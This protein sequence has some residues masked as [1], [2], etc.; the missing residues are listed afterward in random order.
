M[1]HYDTTTTILK[2]LLADRLG[3]TAIEYALIAGLVSIA[4][5]TAMSSMG[6]TIGNSFSNAAEIM[7]NS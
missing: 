6:N 3:A 5:V 2:R 7:E 1:R 4:A